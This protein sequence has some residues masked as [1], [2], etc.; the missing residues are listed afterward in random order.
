MD[1]MSAIIA[2]TK[3][4]AEGIGLHKQVGTLKKGKLADCLVLQGN[5]LE[6]IQVLASLENILMIFK[7]GELVRGEVD[8]EQWSSASPLGPG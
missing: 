3:I 8:V 1:E 4:A 7:D 5:P 2:S 6:D